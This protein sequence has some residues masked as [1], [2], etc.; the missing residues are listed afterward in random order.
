MRAL[1]VEKFGKEFA[2]D[3]AE[4]RTGKVA[5]R[6]VAKLRVEPPSEEL[7]EGYLAEIARTYGVNWPPRGDVEEGGDGEGDD[8]DDEP[9]SGGRAV[10]NDNKE[11]L[12]TP[13]TTEELSRATPPRDLGPKS[14]VSVAPPSPRTENL[15]PRVKVAGAPLELKPGGNMVGDGGLGKKKGTAAAAA[16]GGS[17]VEDGDGERGGG[18]GRGGVKVGGKIPD[19]DDL[20]RR[21]ADLKRRG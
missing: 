8:G 7:V 15:S 21:F 19:V 18:G 2:L 11:D 20:Q 5:E 14:P 1:L 12:E 4:N 9:G 17:E 10:V 6:V 3:A 16:A 13:L